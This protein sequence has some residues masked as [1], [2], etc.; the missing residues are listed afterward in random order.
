ME[1]S[2]GIIGF[3]RMAKAIIS[4]LLERGEFKP[5]DVFGIVGSTSSISSAL[6]DLPKGVKIVSSE[7]ALS[8]DAWSAP[9][10]LLAVK[11]QQFRK[12]KQ[13]SISTF[14]ST[15]ECPKPILIS[16]LAGITLKSLKKAFPDHTCVRAVPN[17]PSLVREGLTGLAWEH[18]I[19]L[20]QKIAVKKIFEPI[21]EIFELPERQL[22]PFLALTS[23]GPAYIA[24][25]VEAM[26][27]GAVASGLPRYLSNQLAHKTLSGTASL[28]REKDLHPAELKD[29]VASPAGTTIS[30]L[31][32]LELAGLR[33]ALIEAVVLAA[34]KS[35]QLAEEVSI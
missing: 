12:I 32:H 22:D 35:R 1:I 2:I 7:D 26:A 33:S 17:T 4:P 30:A 9:L 10:K 23:S 27:D 11:P 21:S 24:L 15:D 20:E 34:E 3:G 13:C 31:R 28:L 8:K 19:T 6:S 18:D 16:V 29:M 25:V 5:E 14:S